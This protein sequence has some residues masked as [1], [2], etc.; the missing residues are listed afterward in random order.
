MHA[1]SMLRKEFYEIAGMYREYKAEDIEIT[2]R[3]LAKGLGVAKLEEELYGYR[4]RED[5]KSYQQSSENWSQGIIESKFEWLVNSLDANFE[6]INY[7]IWGADISGKTAKDII[8]NR[9]EEANCLGFIDLMKAGGEFEGKTVIHPD[10]I[11]EK[12]FD[13]VFICTQAGAVMARKT[14][15]ELGYKEICE[16]FKLS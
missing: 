4:A 5:S 12:S 16:Y 7:Y 9:F 8:E 10:D 14:M 3:A 15:K 6:K 2:F 13:Y 1:S 11:K